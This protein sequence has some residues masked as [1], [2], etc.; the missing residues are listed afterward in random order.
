MNTNEFKTINNHTLYEINKLGN[1]R[2]IKNQRIYKPSPLGKVRLI[3]DDTKKYTNRSIESL[4][5]ESFF[6]KLEGKRNRLRF[7]DGIGYIEDICEQNH[8]ESMLYRLVKNHHEFKINANKN[9]KNEVRVYFNGLLEEDIDYN[10]LVVNH[11][12]DTIELYKTEKEAE[13]N[14]MFG[15]EIYSFTMT[16]GKHNIPHNSE[17]L[18]HVLMA[19]Y[20][21]IKQ[22]VTEESPEYCSVKDVDNLYQV[23]LS[24][25][26]DNR[27]DF[28]LNELKIPKDPRPY[29][30]S[31]NRVVKKRK[32]MSDMLPAMPESHIAQYRIEKAAELARERSEP[33]TYEKHEKARKENQEATDSAYRGIEKMYDAVSLSQQIAD[34]EYREMKAKEFTDDGIKN[35]EQ[36]VMAENRAAIKRYNN[37]FGTNY[38]GMDDMIA[39][40]KK[41]KNRNETSRKNAAAAK[42]RQAEK[43]IKDAEKEAK[44]RAKQIKKKEDEIKQLKN[45]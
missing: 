1:V 29:V 41:D 45:N 11:E 14:T 40:F 38:N 42:I 37:F 43:D 36:K 33:S 16:N 44:K 21:Y 23:Y 19:K 10:C 20:Y 5:C 17:L 2:S 13:L 18:E 7:V 31:A 32:T 9:S 12:N 8:D 6:P 27:W 34:N 26:F 4:V 39:G 25:D 22:K 28:W 35:F 30:A 24:C 15:D 3:K